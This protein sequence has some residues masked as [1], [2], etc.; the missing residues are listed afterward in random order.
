MNENYNDFHRR[1]TKRTFYMH[2]K[3]NNCETFLSTKSHTPFKKLDNFRYVFIYKK[4]YTLR[5]GIFY[6]F[7]EIGIYIQKAW[8]FALRDVFIYKNPYTFQKAW[9]F[10]LP[11][12]VQKFRHFTL[13][14]FWW[15]LWNWHLYTKSMTLYVTW[16]FYIQKSRIL[17]KSTTIYA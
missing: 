16:H 2:T 7:F 12:Y 13:R 6:E 1:K 5:C 10:V 3:Q 11:F 9:Q 8:H 15:N 17:A 4:Q 14:N